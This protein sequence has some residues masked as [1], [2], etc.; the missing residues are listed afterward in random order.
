MKSGF[1]KIILILLAV[2]FFSCSLNS[3]SRENNESNKIVNYDGFQ[4]QVAND[5][6]PL[7]LNDEYRNC[8]D[9]SNELAFTL[10]QKQ[11]Q[12]ELFKSFTFSPLSVS[13]ALAMTGNGASGATLKEIEAL[14]GPSTTSNSFYSKYVAHFSPS[15][16]MSNYMAIN[17]NFPVNQDFIKS[18]KGLYN[19]QVSNLDFSTDE[20]TRRINAWI[21]QQSNGEFSNIVK[22]TNANELVYLI[23]YL[24]FKALWVNPFDKNNTYDKAFTND[25]GTSTQVPTM[26]Q[27]FRELYYEDNSCQ[28]ISMKYDNSE[29]RMLIVL[30]KDQKINDFVTMMNA[31]EFNH[32]I[33]SLKVTSADIDLNLPRFSTNCNL[34]LREM[35]MAMMPTA[36]NEKANFGR[37]SKARSYIN[38]FTQDTKITVN[39]YGTEA[40]G[41]TVQSFIVKAMHPQFNANHPFLYF[42]Y[43]EATHAILLAGQFCG[44]GFEV[45]NA[46]GRRNVDYSEARDEDID[47]GNKIFRSC[48]HMPHFPG[49][50]QALMSFIKNNMIYPQEALKNKIEGRVIMQFVVTRTGRVGQVKMAR[51]V[52][53]DLDK[54]AVRLCKMLPNFSPGRNA[55]GEKVD[56][57][58]TLPITFKLPANN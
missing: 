16:I 14:T 4:S 34:D 21:K 26:F 23:N 57:W 48:S 58:Y 41:V 10:M 33:S 54:E 50:D 9:K 22:Q 31:G 27:Y 11:S 18:I 1:N 37:L 3:K 8:I 17:K 55:M 52:N 15:V 39:E 30:P 42:I 45:V 13:Y 46:D 7:T 25:N 51:A 32:I 36:F 35:L 53:K 56:V 5:N 49:G 43:D 20:A 29:F 12:N 6:K 47:D 19:A 2:L 28:A 44:D 24:R 38:R 40:S